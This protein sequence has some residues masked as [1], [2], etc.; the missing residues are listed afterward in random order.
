[1]QAIQVQ[2]TSAIE[3]SETQLKKITEAVE[4]K[5]PK[6]KIE[7]AQVVDP[8]IIGGIKLIVDAVEYDGTVIGKLDRLK[9]HLQK[10]L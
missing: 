2:V 8:K 1:M 5:Y 9:Q 7:V 3:L 6:R 10:E 4:N